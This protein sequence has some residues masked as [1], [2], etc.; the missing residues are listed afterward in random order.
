MLG[1]VS[2]PTHA[3]EPIRNAGREGLIPWFLCVFVKTP[4]STAAA[5]AAVSSGDL[6]LHH[7]SYTKKNQI[8]LLKPSSGLTTI[9]TAHLHSHEYLDQT[10]FGSIQRHG[11]SFSACDSHYKERQQLPPSDTSLHRRTPGEEE[12]S[13]P[14]LR[15]EQ[16]GMCH[17]WNQ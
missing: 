10:S 16:K 11:S 17:I 4:L 9:F 15:N 7:L 2:M 13:H 8:Q 14:E 6:L 12:V 5:G 1:C 3:S